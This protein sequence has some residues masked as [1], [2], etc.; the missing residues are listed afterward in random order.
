MN[1]SYYFDIRSF[2]RIKNSTDGAPKPITIDDLVFLSTL[3]FFNIVMYELD[4]LPSYVNKC[5]SHCF[6]LFKYAQDHPNIDHSQKHIRIAVC[7][8]IV[9]SHIAMLRNEKKTI[10]IY[11]CINM[12][13]DVDSPKSSSSSEIEFM[14]KGDFFLI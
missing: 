5:V 11:H 12:L 14:K 8:L 13:S 3:N 2:F 9:N 7:W 10:W 4:T 6:E 1:I